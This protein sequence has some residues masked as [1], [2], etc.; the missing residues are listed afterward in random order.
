MTMPATLL[1]ARQVAIELDRSTRTAQQWLA[2]GHVRTFRRGRGVYCLRADFEKW[3][4]SQIEQQNRGRRAGP[5][6]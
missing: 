4:A 2:E 5:N 6:F 3:A 1:S